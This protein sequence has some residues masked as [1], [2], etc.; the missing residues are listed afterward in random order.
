MTARRLVALAVLGL[1]LGLA[2]GAAAIPRET[3]MIRARAFTYHPWRCTSANLAPA[4]CPTGY[5]SS[6]EP[7]DYLGLPY[8]WGGY[9]T[10]FEFDQ[11]IAQGYGA[12]SPAGGDILD[13][14]A[15]VD[16]SA[17]VSQC[18]GGGYYDTSSLGTIS[19]VI[20][21]ANMLPGDV[22]N[23]AGYHVVLY[24]RTLGSGE[25][26]FYES[27]PPNVHLNVTG[28]WS[29]VSGYTPLRYT[30]IEGTTA[31]DPVGTPTNPIVIGSLP[32]SDTRNT[33]QSPSDALDGC[34]AAPGSGESGPEYVYQVTFT[35]PGTLTAAVADDATTDIDIH[36]YTS[37]N[38]SDCIARDNT[39]I[40]VPVDCGTYYL[41]AD[42][43]RSSGGTESPG[44][45]TLTASFTPSGAACGAG[46]PTYHPDGAPG[47]PC[48]EQSPYC[49]ATL[50][51]DACLL[52]SA[53]SGFCSHSCTTASDCA[54]MPGG[55]GCCRTLS[56]GEKYCILSSLCSDA[57]DGGLT[58]GGIVH[59]DGGLTLHDG[60]QT[61]FDG[62]LVGPEAGA[63]AGPAGT[64]AGAEVG[65]GD[66]G[67]GGGG[68]PVPT[69]NGAC[70]CR[71]PGGAPGGTL[72]ALLAI[73][74]LTGPRRQ[75]FPR[76]G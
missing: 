36:L 5:H 75:R 76:R 52:T 7:G 71:A 70:G 28:G 56:S 69:G 58:D 64:E 62:G 43:F 3:V 39:T 13:C 29:W 74:L 51:A 48:N 24:S 11:Q 55:S 41:V 2:S 17:F 18:W 33:A 27:F 6:L 68:G 44:Q 73:T 8:D 42:T 47:S 66:D 30:G 34:G 50:G 40:T 22:F 53:T 61:H 21:Q 20:A 10:L 65:P 9:M 38:T 32:Y 67:S 25:P 35:Q 16:C 63:E 49:N 23:K 59:A 46:P 37:M 1:L 26:E 15:G 14:T 19:T 12:G 31:G 60:G 72:G 54:D 45:Y 57:P 4:S